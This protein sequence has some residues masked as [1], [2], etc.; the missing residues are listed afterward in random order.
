MTTEAVD[1]QHCEPRRIAHPRPGMNC[2][3]MFLR[4][5]LGIVLAIGIG[6]WLFGSTYGRYSRA[7]GWREE[8]LRFAHFG[9]FEDYEFWRDVIVDFERQHPPTRV[10]QEYI[11]GLGEHYNTKLRQQIISGTLPDMALIQLGPFHELAEHFADVTNLLESST[12][13]D[14]HPATE[15][16]SNALSAFHFHG[17]QR[18]LPVSGGSLVIYGNLRCFERARRLHEKPIPL[19][20]DDWTIA[21]FYRT[22]QQLTCDFDGDGT[23]EQFGFWLP[24]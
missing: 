18:A 16:H 9:S 4:R 11:V 23:I 19:P 17:R 14:P 2:A 24:T 7:S 5:T 6:Y 10:R 13:G 20:Q 15:I 3:I 12:N 22:A 8:A 21:D 1:R